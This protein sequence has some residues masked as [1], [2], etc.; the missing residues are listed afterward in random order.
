MKF[1]NVKIT[2]MY[3]CVIFPLIKPLFNLQQTILSPGLIISYSISF[4]DLLK[5]IFYYK[6]RSQTPS[7]ALFSK[8]HVSHNPR[9]CQTITKLNLSRLSITITASYRTQCQSQP[10]P[11]C[12]TNAS[13]MRVHTRK[14]IQ[15]RMLNV[16][17][18]KYVSE[19]FGCLFG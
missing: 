13:S 6:T 16:S 5:K 19:H 11:E 1:S 9:S 18:I 4:L 3:G 12:Q 2:E 10:S 17:C 7:Q 8:P 14:M 15:C